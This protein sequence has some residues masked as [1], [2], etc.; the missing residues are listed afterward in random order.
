[1][2]SAALGMLTHEVM[3]ISIS[4]I[5]SHTDV[6]AEDEHISPISVVDFQCA[7]L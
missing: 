1:M 7:K 6:A 3:H 5:M 2:I 4:E